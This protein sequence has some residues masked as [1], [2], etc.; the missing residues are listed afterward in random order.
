MYV[1]IPNFDKLKVNEVFEIV[2]AFEL[3]TVDTL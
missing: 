2:V 1:H 3:S